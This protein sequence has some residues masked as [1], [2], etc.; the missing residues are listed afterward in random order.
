M[1]FGFTTVNVRMYK[2]VVDHFRGWNGPLGHSISRLARET[3]FRQRAMVGKK[4]G[5]LAASIRVGDKGRWPGGIQTTVGAGAGQRQSGHKGYAM[6]NDQGARPHF[7]RPR[8]PGGMLVFYWAKVG[9][10]VR[11]PSVFHPGN[12]PYHWAERGL[13]AA[14]AQWERGG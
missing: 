1:T 5:L 8:R 12:R 13:R 11:L 6:A 10:V 3:A 2:P 9:R 14:M 7:I 4:S